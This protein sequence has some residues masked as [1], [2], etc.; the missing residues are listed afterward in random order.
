MVSNVTACKVQAINI[1]WVDLF[2]MQG[3]TYFYV[4]CIAYLNGEHSDI[5]GSFATHISAKPKA[6]AIS[7]CV[8]QP[9]K[10]FSVFHQNIVL[11][12][13]TSWTVDVIKMRTTKCQWNLF[14]ELY[15]SM[16]SLI[17]CARNVGMPFKQIYP[18]TAWI[19]GVSTDH[20]KVKL[21][22][23]YNNNN[24]GNTIKYCIYVQAWHS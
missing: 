21:F 8:L 11:I 18:P 1:W 2:K 5:S 13:C 7:D 20:I 9:S 12:Q 14:H 24:G 4:D 22:T 15:T 19:L 6:L 3:L 16:M 10:A 17:G 23:V